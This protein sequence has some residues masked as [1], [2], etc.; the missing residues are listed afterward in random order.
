[1]RLR[2]RW[3]HGLQGPQPHVGHT[4]GLTTAKATTSAAT[5][6]PTPLL[7][8]KGQQ[9]RHLGCISLRL[10]DTSERQALVLYGRIVHAVLFPACRTW[11]VKSEQQC[12]KA[13]ENSRTA[14]NH[15][16]AAHVAIE[17]VGPHRMKNSPRGHPQHNQKDGKLRVHRVPIRNQKGEVQWRRIV[18]APRCSAK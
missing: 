13:Q 18:E 17:Q 6:H 16:R 3:A 10:D 5:P 14:Q 7:L 11:F 15:G 2:H 8:V 9:D 4:K 1:M 12:P